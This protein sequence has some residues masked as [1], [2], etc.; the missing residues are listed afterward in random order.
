MAN[1]DQRFGVQL[2][3]DIAEQTD[4]INEPYMSASIE[5]SR[6]PYQPMVEI[7]SRL[8]GLISDLTE[9][10]VE[11]AKALDSPVEV[12]AADKVKAVSTR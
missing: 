10:G 12:V 9:K 7:E 2:S 5:Y 4:G 1:K 11:A 3:L 8:V 6:M